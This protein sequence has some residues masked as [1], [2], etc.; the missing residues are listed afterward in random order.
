M[1]ERPPEIT[2]APRVQDCQLPDSGRGHLTLETSRPEVNRRWADAASAHKEP[3]TGRRPAPGPFP[4][5]PSWS[6]CSA[7]TSAAPRGRVSGWRSADVPP[8]EVADRAGHSVEVLLRVYAKCRDDDEKNCL[9]GNS[10]P[11][12]DSAMNTT[13]WIWS[14]AGGNRAIRCTAQKTG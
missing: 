7:T 11:A 14:L 12:S 4:S 3:Q 13:W 2:A 9:I 8:Q 5:R 1:R 6:A 10:K